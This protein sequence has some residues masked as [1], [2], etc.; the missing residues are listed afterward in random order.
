MPSFT[1]DITDKKG[2]P[3]ANSVLPVDKFENKKGYMEGDV[4]PM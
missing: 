2:K 4:K 1:C 3:W